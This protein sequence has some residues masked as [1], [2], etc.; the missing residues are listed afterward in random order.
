MLSKIFSVVVFFLFVVLFIQG[1]DSNTSRT[2][3]PK[4]RRSSAGSKEIR[5]LR[6]ALAAQ[7]QQIRRQQT[8][9]E[10]QQLTLQQLPQQLLQRDAASRNAEETVQQ[11]NTR[12]TAALERAS[13]VETQQA[14][15]NTKL[16]QDVA[17]VRANFASAAESA[18]EQ[19]SKV[20]ALQNVLGRFQGARRK[21]AEVYQAGLRVYCCAISAK[22]GREVAGTDRRCEGVHPLDTCKCGQARYRSGEDCNRRIFSRRPACVVCLRHPGSSGIRRYG[23]QPRRQHETRGV[24]LV[25]CRDR[26]VVEWMAH[27]RPAAKWRGRRSL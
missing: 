6:Q 2:T 19:Q 27:F 23:R 24:F 15:S 9:L 4:Q 22:R 17:Q 1:S 3:P 13:R 14:D 26:A 12:A 20:S 7:Q 16:Q 18:Q 11:L 8:I 21:A 5:G 10:Q 25:L